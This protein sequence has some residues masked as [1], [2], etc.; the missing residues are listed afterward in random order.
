MKQQFLNQFTESRVPE[1]GLKMNQIFSIRATEE[2]PMRL[3][4][5]KTLL[6]ILYQACLVVYSQ[7]KLAAMNI[8]IIEFPSQWT[9]F[10]SIPVGDGELAGE[11]CLSAVAE[12]L[13]IFEGYC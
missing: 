8:H 10:V 5:F 4:S 12:C 9:I 2:R 1:V 13:C 3:F 7:T 6:R 11:T